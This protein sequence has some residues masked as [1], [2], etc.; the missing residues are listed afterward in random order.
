[1]RD[2][3]AVA[4]HDGFRRLA[5]VV[6]AMSFV[7][8]LMLARPAE[9]H[10][11]TVCPNNTENLLPP[12]KTECRPVC[13]TPSF[14]L[15]AAATGL[16]TGTFAATARNPVDPAPYD[17]KGDPECAVPTSPTTWNVKK[18]CAQTSELHCI[19]WHEYLVDPPIGIPIPATALVTASGTGGSFFTGWSS[20]CAPSQKPLV[21]R[22]DCSILMDANKTV[23]AT[24]AL[25]QDTAAPSAPSLT[26]DRIN[27]NTVKLTWTA[28]TDETWL[29]GYEILRNGVLYTARP[30]ASAATTTLTLGNQLCQTTYTWQVRAFDSTAA[31]DSNSVSIFM[32]N[33]CSVEKPPNTILHLCVVG[34]YARCSGAE[35]TVT[36]RKAYF[37]WGANRSHVR[38]QC[39]LGKRSRL[40]KRCYPGKTYKDLA[41]GPH[42]FRVR[43]YDS[44]GK[45]WTPA[46]YRW[47][48]KR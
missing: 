43:A 14:Q 31:T 42:T 37:H 47:T 16:G 30:R 23:T 40:W 25:S 41:L 3:E 15:T 32:G 4:A 33:V 35:R 45:D 17:F 2:R 28:S 36:S 9:S 21:A 39:K 8:L 13:E 11:A 1:M 19:H 34:K 10:A 26:V 5:W 24:F 29:G 48:I 46:K 22:T 12:G 27:P 38:Y 6:L 20:N 18:F 44:A 7:A